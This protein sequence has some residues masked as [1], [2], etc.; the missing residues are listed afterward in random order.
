VK[1]EAAGADKQVSQEGNQEDL[2]MSI[3]ATADNTLDT[4]PHKH[5]VRQ[6]VD[7]LGGV[8]S[9]IIVLRESCQSQASRRQP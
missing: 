1:E 6:S 5:E 7:N 2:V 3:A 8:R 4:Q 9:R